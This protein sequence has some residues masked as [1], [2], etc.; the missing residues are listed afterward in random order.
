MAASDQRD[1]DMLAQA[2]LGT[3]ITTQPRPILA[4]PASGASEVGVTVRP[5]V[6]FPK[7]ITPSTLNS[8]NFYAS[9]AGRKLPA[10][11]VP[12]NDGTFAWLFL[13]PSMPSASQIQ[14]AVDGSTISVLS[15]E[16]LDANA[17]RAASFHPARAEQDTHAYIVA[18]STASNSPVVISEVMASNTSTLAD[19]QG[20][21]DD[22][23]E[24]RNLTDQEVDLAGRY[25]SDEPNNPRK[26]AFP[27][28]T[29]IPAD[30][31][32][33]VWCDEDGLAAPGLHASFK[34]S[35]SGEQIFLTDSDANLNAILDT[36]TFTSLETDRSYA[37]TAANADVWSVQTPSPG[38]ANQ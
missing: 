14:V 19:P 27:A 15:G 21:F 35:A 32:L 24:L 23:I 33:I 1:V 37:R 12:A 29:K 13:D 31:C 20:E 17:A 34:L 16:I 38:T 5:R 2:I 8:N 36:V 22:W 10:R 11:I 18:V 25:L 28:G 30:G 4:E 9:F 26:W 7:P 3:P 6:Y